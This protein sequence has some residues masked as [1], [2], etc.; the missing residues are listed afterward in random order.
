MGAGERHEVSQLSSHV[1]LERE[2]WPECP[3]H[4]WPGRGKGADILRELAEYLSCSGPR[5]APGQQIDSDLSAGHS[6]LLL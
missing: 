2:P 1:T 3:V 5:P 4:P 6:E